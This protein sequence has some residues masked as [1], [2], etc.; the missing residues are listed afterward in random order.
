VSGKFGT[1]IVGEIDGTYFKV[2]CEDL[3]NGKLL[4]NE[5]E[6]EANKTILRQALVWYG[7]VDI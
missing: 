5:I 1:V 6:T 3:E 2:V 7:H 4:I